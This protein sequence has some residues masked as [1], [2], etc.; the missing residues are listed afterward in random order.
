MGL[1]AIYRAL[2]K[3]MKPGASQ[4]RFDKKPIANPLFPSPNLGEKRVIRKTF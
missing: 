4:A 2:A 1:G 3:V